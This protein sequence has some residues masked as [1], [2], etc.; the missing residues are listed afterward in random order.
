MSLAC[1][2]YLH[3]WL[4]PFLLFTVVP[5]WS[6][7]ADSPSVVGPFA[8]PPATTGIDGTNSVKS[9]AAAV[10]PSTVGPPPAQG[11]SESDP[12]FLERSFGLIGTTFETTLHHEDLSLS[13]ETMSRRLDAFFGS[14]R[15]YEETIGTDSYGSVTL[16]TALERGG[17]LSFDTRFRL[18]LDLP[19]TEQRLKIRFELEDDEFDEDEIGF[20]P[21]DDTDSDEKSL[22][23]SLRFIF[24]ETQNWNVSLS[25]GLKV[26]ELD[27]YIKLRLRRSFG[28]YNWHGRF[29]QMFE[30][31]DSHGYGSKSTLSFDRRLDDKSLLRLIS[32][33]YR[34]E[35]EYVHNDF[36]VSQRIRLLHALKPHLGVSTEAGVIGYTRPNWHHDRYFCNI[37]LRRDIHEGYVFF[38]IRPQ[39]E[40]DRERDFKPECSIT[41]SLEV[42]YGAD[43]YRR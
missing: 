30:W 19:R 43:Y 11:R 38:E 18:R 29:V 8:G 5:T 23:A 22:S 42:L 10:A 21:P 28:L 24:Q 36:K 26:R 14:D 37:R 3:R 20:Y 9:L 40:F 41:L 35:G 12:G 39:V 2:L 25:P 33:A 34:N 17:G 16:S 31:F 15:L 13:L 4:F 7:C 6:A 27:P 32:Q 1:K